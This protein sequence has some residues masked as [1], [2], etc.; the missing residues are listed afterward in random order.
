MLLSE[1]TCLKYLYFVL[2]CSSQNICMEETLTFKSKEV[3]NQDLCCQK[4][5][6]ELITI[7]LVRWVCLMNK[8]SL[9]YTKILNANVKHQFCERYEKLHSTFI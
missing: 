8:D 3:T 2:N 5:C 1:K 6:L 7:C 4:T 9:D